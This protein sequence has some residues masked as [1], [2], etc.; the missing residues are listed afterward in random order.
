[1]SYT[2]RS[3][4]FAA[5]WQSAVTSSQFVVRWRTAGDREG[6]PYIFRGSIIFMGRGW[7]N[8]IIL[9][10]DSNMAQTVINATRNEIPFMDYDC[11]VRD[12][13]GNSAI[14]R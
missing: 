9:L 7:K 1:M 12:F 10:P 8:D 11:R 13:I 14:L 4:Q 3:W 6:R 2:V 5:R